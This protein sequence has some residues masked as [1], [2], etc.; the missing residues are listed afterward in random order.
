MFMKLDAPP[1]PTFLSLDQHVVPYP[2]TPRQIGADRGSFLLELGASPARA[3][4]ISNSQVLDTLP[5]GFTGVWHLLERHPASP[6]PTDIPD[7]SQLL[8][9]H[10]NV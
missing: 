6:P 9:D 5:G 7:G 3:L 8:V 4:P 10:Y 2:Q 1:P